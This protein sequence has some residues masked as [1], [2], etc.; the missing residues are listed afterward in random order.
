MAVKKVS[1][2][3]VVFPSVDRADLQADYGASIWAETIEP[4]LHHVPGCTVGVL[5]PDF[6]GY[7]PALHT[8]F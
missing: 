6:L 5:T 2:R 8:V 1:L 3:H 7:H 4:I